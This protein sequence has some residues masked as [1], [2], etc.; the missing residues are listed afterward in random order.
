MNLSFAEETA[1]YVVADNVSIKKGMDDSGGTLV[2]SNLAV[3]DVIRIE[4]DGNGQ[5]AAVYVMAD[6]ADGQPPE[7]PGNENSAAGAQ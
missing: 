4:L 7:R 6:G 2:V 3:D 5:V 1:S